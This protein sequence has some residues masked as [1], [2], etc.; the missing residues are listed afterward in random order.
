VVVEQASAAD[1]YLRTTSRRPGYTLHNRPS[2]ESWQRTVWLMN[3][4]Q[5]STVS[6]GAWGELEKSPEGGTTCKVREFAVLSD[7]REVTLLDDR[8]WMTSAPLHEITLTHV[9]RNLY[10]AVLPDDARETGEV[11]E[12]QRFAQ[13][14]LESGV[15]VTSDALRTLPYQVILNVPSG[16]AQWKVR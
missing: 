3:A 1:R 16:I 5:A 6:L 14:L 10:T 8:G 12:W 2:S 9:V 11:H 7:G 4:S 15:A 13:R